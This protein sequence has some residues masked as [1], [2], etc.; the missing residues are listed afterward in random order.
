YRGAEYRLEHPDTL[1][2]YSSN[3]TVVGGDRQGTTAG[4]LYY[5]SRGLTGLVF[6]LTT[7][8]LREAYA[9]GNP[10]FAAA[11]AQLPFHQSLADY[12]RKT[13]LYR[14]TALYRA[15]AGTP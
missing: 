8:Y 14:V 7:H 9:A 6:P 3:T 13:G 1:C 2:V 4:R 10:A 5:F 12:D 15:A 11:L